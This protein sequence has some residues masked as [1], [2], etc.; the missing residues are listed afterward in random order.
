VSPNPDP[1][2]EIQLTEREREVA[3][4]HVEV[5]ATTG[6]VKVTLPRIPERDFLPDPDSEM[7]TVCNLWRSIP[8]DWQYDAG[9]D[10]ETICPRLRPIISWGSVDYNAAIVDCVS[11][12]REW[13]VYQQHLSRLISRASVLARDARTAPVAAATQ[14]AGLE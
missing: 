1:N 2:I 3:A 12:S 10:I 9:F 4:G 7:C 14:Q 6:T 13:L 8:Y 5:D 11:L